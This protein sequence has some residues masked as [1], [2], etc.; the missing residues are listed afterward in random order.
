[1]FRVKQLDK[2]AGVSGNCS[3]SGSMGSSGLT[4]TAV[5]SRSNRHPRYS[6]LS[7][8]RLFIDA[9]ADVDADGR[10]ER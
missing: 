8:E 7:R 10:R 3:G 2:D 4:K 6:D 5:P 1:M 9:F